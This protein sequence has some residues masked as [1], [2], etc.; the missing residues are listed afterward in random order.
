MDDL[1]GVKRYVNDAL[2]NADTMALVAL[3]ALF[4][5]MQWVLDRITAL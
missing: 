5:D 1:P 4:H 2:Q 3:F